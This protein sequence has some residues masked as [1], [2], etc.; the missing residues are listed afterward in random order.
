MGVIQKLFTSRKAIPDAED[1]IGSLGRLWFDQTSSTLRVGDGITPG[2]LAVLSIPLS[3][4]P[5]NILIQGTDGGLF[6]VNIALPVSQALTEEILNRTQA[7]EL[8]G[9]RIDRVLVNLD[10]SVL[11]NLSEIVAAIGDTEYDF[12]A[13]YVAAR[14]ALI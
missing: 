12:T 11:D 8:L 6:V 9:S 14:D 4:D 3:L 1:Y 7:D 10:P 2:G 13:A 5:G